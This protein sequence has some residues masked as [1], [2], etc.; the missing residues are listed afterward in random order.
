M[1][2]TRKLPAI[3]PLLL[4][5]PS[6]AAAGAA[7]RQVTEQTSAPSSSQASA[8]LAGDPA[9]PAHA[10]HWVDT[11]LYFELGP[12]LPPGTHPD[13]HAIWHP[14]HKPVTDAQWMRFLDREVT[15]R[16]PDGLSVLNVY[17]QWKGA[18]DATPHRGRSRVLII[19]YPE[20]PQNEARIDAIRSAWKQMTGEQSVLKVTVPADVSF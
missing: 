4:L 3:L 18:H 19:D 16:F 11:H 1:I 5:L 15:P 14:H 17:G 20:N 2:H 9:H 13:P 6:G 12:Y 10:D 7:A 8:T